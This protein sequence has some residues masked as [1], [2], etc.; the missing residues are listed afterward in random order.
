MI[1]KIGLTT[2]NINIINNININSLFA[3]HALIEFNSK[4]YDTSYG[5]GPFN[6]LVEWEDGSIDAFGV[7]V[8]EYGSFLTGEYHK[9]WIEKL[10]TKGILEVK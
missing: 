9:L 5:T 7:E 2:G 8:G 6:S 3:D 10:D 4:I 1:L